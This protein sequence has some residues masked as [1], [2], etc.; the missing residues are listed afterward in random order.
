MVPSFDEEESIRPLYEEVKGVLDALGEPWEMIFIDDGSRDRT[1][2]KMDQVAAEDDRAVCYW[3]YYCYWNGWC[4][5]S[6]V[7]F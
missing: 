2:E 4:E 3:Q 7:C 5:Y 6:W 1:V